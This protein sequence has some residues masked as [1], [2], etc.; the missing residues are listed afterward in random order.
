M[1][2]ARILLLI[3]LAI[4]LLAPDTISHQS[5]TLGTAT[6]LAQNPPQAPP[7]R[8]KKPST[9]KEE[10]QDRPQGQ[11]AISV[12]VDLVSLQ[13]L[14]TDQKGN[15]ITGLRP[16]N[17]TIYEDNVKQEITNFTPVE[18]NITAVL[19]VEYSRLVTPYIYDV[20]NAIYTFASSL[21]QGDWVAVIGYDLRPTILQDFTQ[22]RSKLMDALRRFNYPAFSESNLSDALIDT[23]DRVEEIEGKVAVIL[24]SSGLDTFS[25]HTYDEALKKCKAANATVYAIGTGQN[26]RLRYEPYMS[27]E[28]NMDYLMADNRLKSFAEFTGGEAYFP[29]FVTEMP[30]IFGNISNLL[31]NQYSIAYASSNTKK[32]GKFRKLKVDVTADINGDGKPDKLKVITRKGY[33]AKES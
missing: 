4:V 11:T 14:V 13:V 22:D 9:G 12:A 26:F 1:K 10:E 29:R 6:A 15:V 21:R 20:W 7:S 23:L 19:L 32:D 8:R 28:R 33:L 2:S 24:V 25:R 27:P 30:S 3:T 17:F 18:A 16:E 5:A 31:R